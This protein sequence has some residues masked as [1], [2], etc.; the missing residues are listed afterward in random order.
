MTPLIFSCEGTRLTSSEQSFF[1][2]ANPLGFI[3]FKRN[4]DSPDQVKKLT[5]DLRAAL[6]RDC[7]ILID[8]EGGRVQRMGAP[9][10]QA[11]KAAR[12]HESLDDVRQTSRAIARDLVSVGI[13]VNCAPVLDVLCPATH[14]AIGSR[15]YSD[16]PAEVADRGL[17]VCEEFL[18]AGITPVL[19]HIP[20]QGRAASDSHHDLPVIH[21]PYN[22]LSACDFMPFRDISSNELAAACWGMIAHV[23]YTALD[24]DHPATV[25]P[26]IIDTIRRDIG[27]EGLLLSDDVSMGALD[28]LGNPAD[29]TAKILASGVDIALYCAGHLTEMEQIAVIAPEMSEP[30]RERYERSLAAKALRRRSAA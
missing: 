28:F 29:R 8:Q 6:G 7:P 25:S 17:A 10:W 12:D 15:A 26:L 20:G 14:E 27:F 21:T 24:P 18:A 2:Q 1:A 9:H 13:D 11:C 23:T 4:I 3:L 30:A 22:A 16:D 19:K 5:A